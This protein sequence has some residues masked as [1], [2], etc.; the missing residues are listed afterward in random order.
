MCA[1]AVVALPAAWMDLF[2]VYWSPDTGCFQLYLNIEQQLQK[3][4]AR[5]SIILADLLPEVSRDG[6]IPSECGCQ[7]SAA[8]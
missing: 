4:Q 1:T 7:R 3:L 6:P 5:A 8:A 2:H